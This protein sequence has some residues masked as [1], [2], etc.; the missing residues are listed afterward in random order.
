[1]S[2]W[3]IIKCIPNYLTAY[4]FIWYALNLI[5]YAIILG[6]PLFLIGWEIDKGTRI[7]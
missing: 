1:M 2:G 4:K 3:G 6:H 7:D 5:W